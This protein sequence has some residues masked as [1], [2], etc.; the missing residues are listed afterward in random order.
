MAYAPV[1]LHIVSGKGG[2]GKTTVAGALAL[3]L[4]GAGNRV[5][6]AEVE[7][8]QGL[9]QLFDSAPLPATER[10]LAASRGGE[11]YGLSVDPETAMLEYLELFY[12]MKRTGAVLRRMGATDFVT[13]I[14]PGLRDV[15]LTGKVKE[16]VVR[17]DKDGR[18]RYDA[19]VVDAPPTGRIVSFLDATRE[20]AE[21]SKIGPIYKHS[22]G[23]ANLLRS[24]ETA[25]HLVTLLEEMPVQETLDAVAQL[26]AAG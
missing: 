7:G 15:L 10:R 17:A 19:V 24:P 5:L 2:T 11:L 9:A 14:A 3:A 6:L 16:S 23:V 4:A 20:V 13:T 18:L 22:I 1:R 8:R 26:R 25:I 12:S 21:L